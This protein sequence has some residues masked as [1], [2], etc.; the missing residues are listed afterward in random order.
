MVLSTTTISELLNFTSWNEILNWAKST[1]LKIWILITIFFVFFF[2]LHFYSYIKY[3]R[4]REYSYL[5]SFIMGVDIDG[6]LNKHRHH[7]CNLLK[8]NTNI[9]LHP[10][11]ITTIPIHDDPSLGV[12]RENEKQVFNDPRYWT[13][14]PD[15]DDASYNVRRLRNTFKLKIHIFSHRPWPSPEI[16]NKSEDYSRWKEAAIEIL[17]QNYLSPNP[18]WLSKF[19]LGFY[20]TLLKT[21]MEI[22]VWKLGTHPIDII[23][24][25]WLKR[26]KIEYD[27]LVI[28]KGSEDVPDPRGEYRNR[29]NISRGKSIR[30]FVEDDPQ[31]ATKLAYICDVVFL[32][33]HPYNKHVILPKNIIR[34]KSWNEIYQWIKKLS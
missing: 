8:E 15:L 33:N 17:K 21:R 9:S 32:M 22:C 7:F 13:E 30:F 18:S 11:K 2:C 20:K 34:V 29:F 10:E 4:F 12:T 28:E 24:K 26:N 14:M 16:L 31:K 25:C 6:V 19:F 27:D 5:R 3:S 1:P 23:T